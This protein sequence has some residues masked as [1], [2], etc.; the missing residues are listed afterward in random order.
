M[1]FYCSSVY[2]VRFRFL[3][4]PPP[5]SPGGFGGPFG[6]PLGGLIGRDRLVPRRVG[7]FPPRPT[8]FVAAGFLLGAAGTGVLVLAMILLL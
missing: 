1:P 8:L 5:F 7:A 2:Y 3:I 6:G 4:T